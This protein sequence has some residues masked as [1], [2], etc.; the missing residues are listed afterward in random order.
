MISYAS[1]GLSDVERR[2]SKTEKEALVIVWACERFYVY[3]YGVDFEPWTDHKL[4]EFIYSVRSKPS[5]RIE[6]WVLRL[7]PYS[8]LLYLPGHMNIADALSR[9]MK[10]EQA[11]TRNVAQEYIRFVANTAAS[12][13]MTT[14][15]IEDASAVDEELEY[16]RQ[17]AETGN[18]ENSNCANY[19]SIRDELYLFGK[20]VLRGTIIVVAKKLQAR[21]IK[22]GHEGHQG[23]EKNK[24][25]LACKGLVARHRQRS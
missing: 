6:R 25:A 15:E 4:L 3:R 13:A 5:A 11:Q 19:K 18:W 10:I 7:E 23:M 17:S 20:I 9:L 16:V 2:Y 12:Q 24:T 14:E 21:V 8:F 1:S 22:L